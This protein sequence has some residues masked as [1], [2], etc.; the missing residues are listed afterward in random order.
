M[1]LRV[2]LGVLECKSQDNL[3]LEN[4]ALLASTDD[5]L[6]TS[7]EKGPPISS[8]LA[9]ITDG[10]FTADFDSSKRKEIAEKY[11]V[12]ENCAFLFTPRVNPEI[13]VKLDTNPK[14]NDIRFAS[15]HDL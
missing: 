13:W 1:M 15:L 7:L 3:I 12:G 14:H 2:F 5:A 4:E 8:Q 11:H 9:N 10:K 6:V